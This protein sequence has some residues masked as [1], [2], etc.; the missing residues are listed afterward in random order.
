M[1]QPVPR[2]SAQSPVK[3]PLRSLYYLGDVIAL[4]K[5]RGM[6]TDGPALEPDE[7]RAVDEWYDAGVP[8][9]DFV[10]WVAERRGRQPS[11]RH[12]TQA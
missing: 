7:L 11:V 10:E 8:V 9:S 6:L 2:V 12:A 4:L 3:S 1:S 5:F